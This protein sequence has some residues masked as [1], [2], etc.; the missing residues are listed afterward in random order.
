MPQNSS[1]NADPMPVDTPANTVAAMP[2]APG[3]VAANTANVPAEV[4]MP[5]PNSTRLAV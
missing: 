5:A 3:S 2:S 1:S 4:R